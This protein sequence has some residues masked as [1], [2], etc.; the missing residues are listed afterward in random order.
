MANKRID[1]EV[2]K[3]AARYVRELMARAGVKQ[4]AAGH[5]WGISQSTVS[6]VVNGE[7]IGIDVAA[8]IVKAEGGSLDAMFGLSAGPGARCLREADGW[9]AGADAATAFVPRAVVDEAGGIVPP[10]AVDSIEPA[11]VLAIAQAWAAIRS[12][13]AARPSSSAPSS[14]PQAPP[15]VRAD[16]FDDLA[17]AAVE[18]TL[19]SEQRAKAGTSGK[20]KRKR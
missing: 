2:L 13:E 14:A 4:V 19:A 15:P 3:H 18:E 10:R 7:A 9:A 20:A 6:D 12:V 1:P 17:A 5:R 8:C 16:R 11:A